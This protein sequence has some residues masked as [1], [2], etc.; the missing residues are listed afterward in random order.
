MNKFA[1]LFLKAKHTLNKKTVSDEYFNWL[2]YANAG[3]L[4]KGNLYCFDYAIKNLPDNSPIVE[5]GSFCG[6][7]TNIMSFLKKKY[8]K[9]NATITCDRWIFENSGEKN[10]DKNSLLTHAEY[11]EFVME[12][13]KRNVQ[14]FSKG[15]LP[16]T[17]EK[18]SDE[19]FESWDKKEEVKDIFSREITLGGGISFSFIDGN[20]T[21]EYAKRDFDNV[22]KN[23]VKGGFILFDD[24]ADYFSFGVEIL[25]KEIMRDS[26][27]ELVIKNPHYLFRKIEV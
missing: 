9:T 18:F 10:I 13:Y 11:R 17:V 5:I 26:R 24:S 6:L 1:K 20:H 4:E 16:Y 27:Y 7:S 19:F 2:S 3:M 23:L 25:M 8:N 14:F 12:T 22:D 21:Y 15:D